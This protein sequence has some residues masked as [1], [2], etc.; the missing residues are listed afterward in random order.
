MSAEVAQTTFPKISGLNTVAVASIG[1][2]ERMLLRD[3]DSLLVNAVRKVGATIFL[4]ESRVI[5]AL[6]EE[7]IP[8]I[9]SVSQLWT[10]L[11]HLKGEFCV[12]N[13]HPEP[14]RALILKMFDR[15]R[16]WIRKIEKN[17]WYSQALS[18]EDLSS[19]SACELWLP[20]KAARADCDAFF[21][22]LN[23]I[24]G[25]LNRS[26]A[27][28]DCPAAEAL[29]LT[30]VDFDSRQVGVPRAALAKAAEL[31]NK[32]LIDL[33][34][35]SSQEGFL[36]EISPESMFSLSQLL[37]S[38]LFTIFRGQELYGFCLPT[39]NNESCKEILGE[40]YQLLINHGALRPDDKIGWVHFVA[41]EKHDRLL[42]A[43]NGV[44]IYS[45]LTPLLVDS[46]IEEGAN[47]LL[48]SVRE[49]VFANTAI[50]AHIRKGW[51][52]TDI[53]Y[54]GPDGK[55]PYRILIKRLSDSA[56]ES[57]RLEIGFESHFKTS[58]RDP[59]LTDHES[60]KAALIDDSDAFMKLKS[61]MSSYRDIEIRMTRGE[62]LYLTIN[63]GGNSLHLH[64]ILP[65]VDRWKLFSTGT[66]G[67]LEE[68]LP[69]VKTE[70]QLVP[71]I[72]IPRIELPWSDLVDE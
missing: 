40:K 3:S 43:K 5:A 55:T 64:Q 62:R 1:A 68:L 60:E 30:V 9:H 36:R 45:L 13:V 16:D 67:S 72:Y 49:G 20:G 66:R 39:Y 2:R 41:S 21:G 34:K 48:G 6:S 7:K 22:E 50:K 15:T 69:E 23:E 56:R 59:A 54:L 63:R 51:E 42:L 27:L 14:I 52:L 26:T 35:E 65:G 70:L 11:I 61:M 46:A 53:V 4:T 29:Q 31:H 18:A 10:D 19:C 38:R 71:R 47:V 12:Q 17:Y 8:D 57:E 24:Y 44:S 58:A 32:L 33:S 37:Q 25:V 28:A